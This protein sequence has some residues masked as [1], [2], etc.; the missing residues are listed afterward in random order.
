MSLLRPP[1]PI[2]WGLEGAS[3]GTLVLERAFRT[4]CPSLRHQWSAMC[5]EPRTML[6]LVEYIT[7]TTALKGETE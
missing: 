6:V 2:P 3:N 4:G 7:A 5:L 1:P